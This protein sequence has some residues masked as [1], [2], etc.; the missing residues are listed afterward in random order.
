MKKTISLLAVAFFLVAQ[1]T[2]ARIAQSFVCQNSSGNKMLLF[3]PEN[4]ESRTQ[5]CL[6]I[7]EQN[8]WQHEEINAQGDLYNVKLKPVYDSHAV[9]TPADPTTIE[10]WLPADRAIRSYQ[11]GGYY[12]PIMTSVP[13]VFNTVVIGKNQAGQALF[14]ETMTCRGS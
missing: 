8:A 9:A 7:D 10:F 2:N 5:R 4:A 11:S 1:A 3:V 13:F 6:Y 12:F 14:S